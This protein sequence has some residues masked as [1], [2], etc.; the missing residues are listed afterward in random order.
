MEQLQRRLKIELFF[1]LLKRSF[2]GQHAE[3]VSVRSPRRTVQTQSLK[4]KIEAAETG[5]C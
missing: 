2:T 3:L 1:C 5:L 4:E